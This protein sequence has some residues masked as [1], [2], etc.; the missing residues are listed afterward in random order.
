[1]T[2][3]T[4]PLRP[5]AIA[6]RV[7]PLSGVVGAALV[8][9]GLTTAS[10]AV[11]STNPSAAAASIAA[12]LAAERESIRLGVTLALGGVFCLFWFLADLRRRIGEAEGSSGRLRHVAFGGG[13][14]AVAGV[15]LYATLLVAASN[16]SIGGNPGAAQS[17]L[18]LLWEFGG[19]LAPAFAALVAGTSL[20]VLRYRLLPLALRWPAW[21][22][23]PLSLG[24]AVSGFFGG[25]L[26]VASVLWLL[27]VAAAFTVTPRPP[28]RAT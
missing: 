22:G 9:V 28:V 26:V 7:A 23:L 1:M 5:T 11:A 12:T 10:D 20:A 14:V 27:V 24:L 13:L 6:D 16:E 15:V 25:A 19:V 3:R 2:P 4:F 17:L 18:V 8:F 21:I